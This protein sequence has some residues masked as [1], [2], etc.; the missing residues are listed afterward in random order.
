MKK[1]YVSVPVYFTLL[2][3]L[4]SFLCIISYFVSIDNSLSLEIKGITLIFIWVLG[5]L[6]IW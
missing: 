2:V 6:A 4:L 3:V 5:I 1:I